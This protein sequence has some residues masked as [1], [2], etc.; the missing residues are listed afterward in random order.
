MNK[1]GIIF[2]NSRYFYKY[3]QSKKINIDIIG[4]N[5]AVIN[6]ED[7]SKIPKYYIVSS[8]E[9][10]LNKIPLF[11][12]ENIYFIITVLMGLLIMVIASHMIFKIEILHDDPV[13]RKIKH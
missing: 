8:F 13:I 1:I 12:K 10:G 11:V 4:K 5:M 7:L 3:I 6:K 9:I 2:K